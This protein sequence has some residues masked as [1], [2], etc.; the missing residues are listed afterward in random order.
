MDGAAQQPADETAIAGRRASA[1]RG[2]AGR[3][4]RDVGFTRTLVAKSERSSATASALA[5]LQLHANEVE[6][7]DDKP[8]V[9]QARMPPPRPFASAALE[10]V[11]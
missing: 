4:Q 2:A 11:W 10:R 6:A 5:Q 1:S 9:G 7:D 8:V 3:T